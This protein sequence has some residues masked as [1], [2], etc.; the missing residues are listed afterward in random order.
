MIQLIKRWAGCFAGLI[1]ACCL[2]AQPNLNRVEYYIDIDPGYGKATAISFTPGTNLSS[3]ALNINPASL[4]N[5]VHILGIRARDAN[6]GWSLDNKWLF[7][8]P[9]PSD[10]TGPGPVPNLNRVEYYL[11]ADPG[12]GHATAISFTPG[13][14]L[15]NIALNINPA[16]VSSGVHLLG[17]RA[18]D[19]NGRWC[20]DNKWLFAKPYPADSTGPGPVPNLKRIEYYLDVDPGYGKATAISFTPGNSLSNIGLNINPTGLTN[21]VHLLGIRAQD[22]NGH[23]SLDNKWLFAKP[24][25]SD[26]SGPGPVPILKQVEYYFDRDPGFGKGIPVA[27]SSVTNL[28]NYKLPINVA[29]LSGA[30][31]LYIRSKDS[32]GAWSLDN[33][34]NF[35]VSPAVPNPAIVVNSVS[36]KAPCNKDT[37]GV[38]YQ[39]DGTYNAGNVFKVELSDANGSF[40]APKVIGSYTGTGNTIIL[41]SLPDNLPGGNKYRVRVSS[42]NPV[43]TGITGSDSLTIH[44]RPAI[45]TITGDSNANVSISSPYSVPAITG[46]T[47][48]WIVPAATITQTA[49]AANILWNIPGQP[50]KIK[51]IQTDQYGCR[52]DTSVKSVNVYPLRID[53]VKV[54]SLS[55]CPGSVFVVT[56]KAYGEYKAGNVFTAQLSSATGSFSSPVNI[57]K[58]SIHPIGNAQPV[59]IN[60]TMPSSQPNGTG[61]R[62][63]IIGSLP[64]VISGDNGQNITVNGKPD[65]P[66]T[67]SGPKTVTASQAGLVYSVIRK[68]GLTYTWTVP[69]GATINSGQGTDSIRVTWGTAS[70]SVTVKASD[71]C[72]V[73]PIRSL[74]VTVSAAATILSHAGSFGEASSD[75]NVIQVY[76][77]PSMGTSYLVFTA[78]AEDQYLVEITDAAGRVILLKE[79]RSAKGENK[80]LLNTSNYAQGM[81]FVSLLDKVHGRRTLKM[82]KLE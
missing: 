12:Y 54:S 80:I 20:L 16:S 40:A 34:F 50:Q 21:G 57:G 78:T 22:A 71:A 24:Y 15:A 74:S 35:A 43:V 47:W 7:A 46:S 4:S 55:P 77:N 13:N 63:R 69:S 53:S 51:V 76:P 8:K 67:I 39:A 64:G 60:A 49:N 41:S 18:Q 62:V 36:K 5:G 79:G 45:Q 25:P 3:I 58:D 14:N 48:A 82:A 30:H 81:Y 31:V 38:S 59:T 56:A 10:S 52:A 23:W 75:G 9:Y 68:T 27:I 33:R 65:T 11:D 17:I 73:S 6:G 19:A 66:S 72:G 26:S 44:V 37:L 29:G 1:W 32:K 28:P 42:T 61:Y 70:G 2:S